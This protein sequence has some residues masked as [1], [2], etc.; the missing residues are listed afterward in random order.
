MASRVTAAALA[1]GSALILAG[2]ASGDPGAPAAA[3][4][5]S[6]PRVVLPS[7]GTITR[8]GVHYEATEVAPEA[9]ALN[10]R[11]ANVVTVFLFHAD[12][13]STP[14]CVV[15]SPTARIVAEGRTSVVIASFAYESP[16]HGS[17]MCGYSSYRVC[18]ASCSRASPNLLAAIRLRLRAPLGSRSLVDIKTGHEIGIADDKPPTA[19]AYVPRGYRLSRVQPFDASSLFIGIRQYNRDA[20]TLLVRIRSATAWQLRGRLIGHVSVADRPATILDE[21]SERCVSWTLPEGLVHEVCSLAPNGAFLAADEL[22]K[23]ARSIS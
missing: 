7:P 15:L 14:A 18:T 16:G 11:D 9:A 19:P 22:V 17:Q 8:G 1:A 10:R 12:T 20:T 2:C 23:V 5:S 13:A 21:K 3:S 4:R 6:V